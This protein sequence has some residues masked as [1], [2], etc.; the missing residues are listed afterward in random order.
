MK[1][2]T[3]NSGFALSTIILVIFGLLVVGGGVYYV[4][5][6][7]SQSNDLDFGME[8]TIDGENINE[9]ESNQ[10][11]VVIT[12]NTSYTTSSNPSVQGD[13]ENGQNI[14][15]IQSVSG[16]GTS[17]SLVIDY[18][19]LD[20]CPPIN[21]E[22]RCLVNN[23]PMLRTFPISPNATI[24]TFNLNWEPTAISFQDFVTSFNTGA[25]APEN[26][27][28]SGSMYKLNWIT[29]ENGIVV[30]IHPQYLP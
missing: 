29:I 28:M 3:K 11:S 27:V 26:T 13:D 2:N 22:D 15:L 30:A 8:S 16:S 1:T 21:P 23:N 19:Q 24:Q 6:S 20:V 7:S 17:Y 10:E 4:T 18:V 12:T 25:G 9:V 5:Q 14:G